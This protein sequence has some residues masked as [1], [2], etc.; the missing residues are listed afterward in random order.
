MRQVL[1]V[2]AAALCGV[3]LGSGQAALAAE[4]PI[5]AD[6]FEPWYGEGTSI[7]N[8]GKT[9]VLGHLK[10]SFGLL[11]HVSS[12]LVQEHRIEDGV[13][14]VRD[15]IGLSHK[16]E[17]SAA[18]GLFDWVDLGL[19]APLVVAQDLAASPNLV[20]D[21]EGSFSVQDLRFTVRGRF[22]RPDDAAGFGLGAAVTTYLPTG[23]E[24]QLTSDGAARVEPKLLAD[25]RHELGFAVALN[26]GFQLRPERSLL[27]V[28]S[29]KSFRWSV[30][31]QAPLG[32]EGLSA[33]VTAF[34]T[35][36]L[37][38]SRDPQDLSKTI[39]DSR[40]RPAEVDLAVE[41]RWAEMDLV[42]TGG[43]GTA[44]TEGFGAPRW[45]ALLGVAYTP[46]SFDRDGD[47]IQDRDD[48]CPDDPEGM[49][50][51]EDA[52]GCPDPD[53]DGDQ[54]LDADDKC[55]NEAEDKDGFQDADGCPDPDNDAD[56]ILDGEDKCPNEAEDKDGFQDADGCPDPDNDKDGLKD[57]VDKCPNKSE[58]R[59]GFEDL[60]GCPDPDN[61]KDGIPDVRD[62]CPNKPETV[63]Q[64]QDEDGCPDKKNAKVQIS[65][66]HIKIK[67]K[68]FFKTN[69]ANIKKKSFKLL[70]EV[71]KVLN[72]NK[73]I[74]KLRIEGH[75]DSQGG[76]AHNMK[77]S[78]RRAES[79][80]DY[81]IERGV[82]PERLEAKGYGETRPVASN[83]SRK[84]RAANRRTEF[85]ILEVSGRRV[86]ADQG[87]DVPVDPASDNGGK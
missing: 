19:V 17:V 15:I 66:R 60:D 78:Q 85:F 56:G 11:Y 32:V 25:W 74:T 16:L 39:S 45:R 12:G 83:K 2:A 28:V 18:L 86:D 82:A 81:L 36:P 64:F 6:F 72:E 58:D 69:K 46:M 65:K 10:P 4:P 5:Q 29:S 14:S 67:G 80:R 68:I 77:L 40:S 9:D 3:V 63:N 33:L 42:F 35:V 37:E 43:G 41:Y 70:S 79:A 31:G 27:N 84:G 87:V 47:G 54:I 8:V 23:S 38:S 20:M 21:Q 30:A 59:D 34:G 49:D 26:L 55:P 22:L 76:D 73:Q 53:N 44:L 1:F 24:G 13:S 52:N 48:A 75:T 7:L 61:D 51:F 71:A 50:G 62:M 57:G